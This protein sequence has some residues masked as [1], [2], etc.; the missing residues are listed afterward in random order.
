MASSYS[1]DVA[2]RTRA[3]E[4]LCF[5]ALLPLFLVSEGGRRLGAHAPDDEDARADASGWF[6]DALRKLHRDLVRPDG[7]IDVAII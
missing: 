2:S 1:S 4:P 3:S 6:A 7:E 5:R